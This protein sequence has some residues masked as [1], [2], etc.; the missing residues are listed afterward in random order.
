LGR[1]PKNFEHRT[2]NFER[3]DGE[4]EVTEETERKGFHSG[5]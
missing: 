2:R 1:N 4:Q 3:N 5:G